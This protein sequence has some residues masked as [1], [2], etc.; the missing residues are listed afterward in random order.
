[1]NL[2]IRYI[3]FLRKQ[4]SSIQHAHAF[5]FAFT[6]T[7]FVVVAVLYYEY[8]FFRM[9]YN[10]GDV[11]KEETVTENKNEMESPFTAFTNIFKEAG[12]MIK[13]INNGAT[14]TPVFDKNTSNK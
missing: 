2:I 10:R 14:T 6:I 5:L 8:G 12:N 7:M 3:R 9:T 4:H 13:E 11:V 1:M